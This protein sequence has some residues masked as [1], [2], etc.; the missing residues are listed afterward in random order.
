MYDREE[1]LLAFS[2][3]MRLYEVGRVQTTVV[4]Y[5]KYKESFVIRL[6]VVTAY[7]RPT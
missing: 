7:G 2:Q 1:L 4:W 5:N 6:K 3:Q